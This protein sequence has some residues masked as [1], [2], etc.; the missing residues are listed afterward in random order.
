MLMEAHLIWERKRDE[1]E[2]ISMDPDRVL[3]IPDAM[4]EVVGQM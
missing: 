3:V 1:L 2:D 4:R